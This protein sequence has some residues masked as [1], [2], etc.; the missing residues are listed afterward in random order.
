MN[1]Q[2]TISV[3]FMCLVFIIGCIASADKQQKTSDTTPNIVTED[4]QAGIEKHIEDQ[5]SLGKAIYKFG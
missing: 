3:S 4:I 2:K 5:T 1:L